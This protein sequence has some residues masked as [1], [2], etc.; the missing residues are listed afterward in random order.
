MRSLPVPVVG[1]P[2]A[3]GATTPALVA[4]VSDAGGMGF[5]AAGYLTAEK[6]ADQIRE[7][8]RLTSRPIGVN[9]FVIA[10]NEVDAQQLDDYAARI[11]DDAHALGIT[12]GEPRWDDDHYEDKIETLLSTDVDLVSFTFGVPE[13]S[14]VQRFKAAGIAVAV[15]VTSVEETHA[16]QRV[17]ADVLIVQGAEAGGHR[18]AFLAEGPGMPPPLPALVR[19]IRAVSSLPIVAGGGIASAWQAQAVLEAGASAVQIGTA[20]LL[21]D[22]AGTSQTVRDALLSGEFTE[23]TVT[24]AFT[25]RPAR[26]LEND[27]TRHHSDAAPSAF[28]QLHFMTTPLRAAASQAHD[29]QRLHLW[30]GTGFAECRRG[31]AA[32]IVRSM[33]NPHEGSHTP[34]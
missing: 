26:A 15:N 20:L 13:E 17:S 3:G 2:M 28:P 27:F 22:E 21:S 9:L 16:A 11:A 19:A 8:R 29:A 24:R 25:G 18:G 6:L 23:T 34:A 4:A 32:E 14:V 7:T 30:A 10:E 5:L 12:L 33:V 1:A 31:P